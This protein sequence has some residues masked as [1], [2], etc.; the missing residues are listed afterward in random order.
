M[1][2]ELCLDSDCNLVPFHIGNKEHGEKSIPMIALWRPTI[3]NHS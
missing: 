2:F 3:I 1:N